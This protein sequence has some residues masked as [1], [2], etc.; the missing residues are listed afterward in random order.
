MSPAARMKPILPIWQLA[1]LLAVSA[2]GIWLLLPDDPKLVEDLVRDGSYPEARRALGKLSVAKRAQRPDYY[3]AMEVRLSR[4]ELRPHDPA[5]LTAFWKQGVTAWRET[6]FSGT[7]FLE[8]TPVIPRL[9]DP[10]TAWSAMAADFEQVPEKQRERL[11]TDFTHAALAANQPA[12]AAEIFSAVHPPKGRSPDDAL[13]L[14]RLW[15]LADRPADALVALGEETASKVTTRRVALLRA[16]NRNREAFDLLRARADAAPDRTPDAMLIEEIAAVGLAAGLASDTA[17]ILERYVAKNPRDLEA[18]RH[19]RDLTMAANQ[20]VPAV[21]AAQAAV[22]LGQRQP[23]DVRQ[24]ARVLEYSGQPSAAFDAW[25]EL[26]LTGD[27]AATDRLIALNPG[28]YR[29]ADLAPALER[30]VPATGRPDLTLRL[31]R[32]EVTLGRYEQARR[33]LTLYT[34]NA[35]D[36]DALI[37]F[38]HLHT[39]LYRF[40][41]AEALLRRASELRPNDL[42]LRREIAENLVLQNRSADALAAYARLAEQS[43]AE[44]ILGP[45]IRLAES[46]GRYGDFTQGLRR[47][48][49]RESGT[50]ARDYLLLAYGYELLNDPARRA[51]ALE[52]GRRRAPQNDD[53]R[54]QLAYTFA[55]E[56]KYQA[57]QATLATS[58]SLHSNATSSAL[59]LEL[60]RLNNDTAAERRYLATPLS[61]DIAGDESV[62]ERVARAREALGDFAEA[63]KL[64]RSLVTL[65]PTDIDPVAS[66]ARVLLTRGHPAEASKLLA[67]FLVQAAP[68]TIK[69]AAEIAEAAGDHR[70]AEK[71][72][73]AYLDAE[74]IAPPT[75][76]G[77]LGDIRL[78]RGDRTGAKRAYA[79]ALRRLQAQLATKGGAR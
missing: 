13:E 79:E 28:L 57:A 22:A 46:L 32:V 11:A 77:A 58:T 6:N 68:S 5:A 8:L 67:P 78:A 71:Y 16:L 49:D 50:E 62:I 69:L 27:V 26:A 7:V 31:A 76:W 10:A 20:L 23:E 19:L 70:A 37:E 29:D 2:A 64:W 44:E 3:R 53:L 48:I 38:A 75:D 1:L 56:K 9:P 54:V 24:L 18:T 21:K 14:A 63:E 72:Q 47:R 15:Q 42:T 51:A 30:V 65:R 52:E 33:Y 4:L 39:A 17:V 60:M 40:A 35:T 36:V 41:D 73:L 25:L 74:R 43:N 59:Y 55:G 45:Y 61:P 34:A 66:L 12:T